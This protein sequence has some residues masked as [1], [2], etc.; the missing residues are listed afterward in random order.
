MTIETKISIGRKLNIILFFAHV[1]GILNIIYGFHE[2]LFPFISIIQFACPL[3]M[4]GVTFAIA[5]KWMRSKPSSQK[6]KAAFLYNSL[7]FVHLIV[8][9]LIM[10]IL[11]P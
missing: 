6:E 1:L 11:K 8:I 9:C 7:F 4:F 5:L 3:V 2:I 10:L